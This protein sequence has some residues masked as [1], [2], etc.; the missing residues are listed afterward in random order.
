MRSQSE[1]KK[2]R[3]KFIDVCKYLSY[4]ENSH[5]FYNV[6]RVK[7]LCLSEGLTYFSLDPADEL[8]EISEDD[9]DFILAKEIIGYEI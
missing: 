8:L 9:Q 2:V 1:Y 7:F 5:I 3:L 4:F 6:E